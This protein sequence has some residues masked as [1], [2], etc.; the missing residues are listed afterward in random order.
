MNAFKLILIAF[1]LL[2][3]IGIVD[4]R[5]PQVGDTVTITTNGP[6]R[7]LSYYGNITD[8]DNSMITL[9]CTHSWITKP[10]GETV[11][12]GYNPYN[13]SIGKNAIIKLLWSDVNL[14]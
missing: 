14:Y 7:T 13:I 6:M 9:N 1:V 5:L 10:L 11:A 8:I 12:D 3:S 4:A 2:S